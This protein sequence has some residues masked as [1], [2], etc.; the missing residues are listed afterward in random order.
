M[1]VQEDEL[2][3]AMASVATGGLTPLDFVVWP[4]VF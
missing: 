1:P 3:S 4:L 2:T